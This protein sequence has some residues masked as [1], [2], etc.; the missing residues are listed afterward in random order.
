MQNKKDK[1]CNKDRLQ[2]SQIASDKCMQ[3][4]SSFEITTEATPDCWKGLK[5]NTHSLLTD[6]TTP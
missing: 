5:A 3:D 6:T 2:K 1:F 4:I